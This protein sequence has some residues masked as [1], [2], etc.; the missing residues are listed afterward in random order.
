M[1]GA[2]GFGGKGTA[3]AML[4]ALLDTCPSLVFSKTDMVRYF[5]G[6]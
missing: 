3:L 5:L 1:E 4:S 6:F 2:L